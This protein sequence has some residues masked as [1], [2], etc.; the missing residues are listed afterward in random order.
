MKLGSSRF[1]TGKYVAGS[2]AVFVAAVGTAGS[3]DLGG[4]RPSCLDRVRQRGVIGCERSRSGCTAPRRHV[5]V[6]GRVE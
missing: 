5:M 6:V 2:L 4:A 3:P 1:I